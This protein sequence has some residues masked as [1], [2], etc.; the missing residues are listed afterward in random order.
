MKQ[1]QLRQVI[2]EEVRKALKEQ[3][4][5]MKS[6][7][8]ITPKIEIVID[9]LTDV[10]VDVDTMKYIIDKVGLKDQIKF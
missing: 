5:L 8:S 10:E 4:S 7:P 3:T 2:R 6:H 9:T 1:S